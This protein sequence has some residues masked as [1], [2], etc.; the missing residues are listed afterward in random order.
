MLVWIGPFSPQ[1]PLSQAWGKCSGVQSFRGK[2]FSDC[3]VESAHWMGRQPFYFWA[4]KVD[5]RLCK[6]T[7]GK[8]A[9]LDW[10]GCGPPS[11]E[12]VVR[13]QALYAAD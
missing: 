10:C 5:G 6:T 8:V 12:K 4:S 1:G 13:L 3:L 2:I 9:E 7:D 11:E